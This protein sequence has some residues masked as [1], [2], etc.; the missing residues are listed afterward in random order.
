MLKLDNCGIEDNFFDLGGHSL[1]A[2]QFQAR[3]RQ[4]FH[5]DLPLRR[6]F[7]TPTIAGIAADIEAARSSEKLRQSPPL[8]PAERN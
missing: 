6:M 4:E 1:L 8:R 7:E 5:V 3:V 2:I